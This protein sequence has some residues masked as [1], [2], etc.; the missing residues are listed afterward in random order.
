MARR[1][2]KPAKPK[3]VKVRLI[4]RE[5]R[6]G[7]E[8]PGDPY[9]LLDD[10]VGRWHDDLAEAR[11]ALVW[12]YDLKADKDGRLELGKAKKCSD[13][14]RELGAYDLAIFLNYTAW[15]MF[16]EPQRRALLDYE[17]C[18]CAVTMDEVTGEPKQDERGRPVY[19]TR[20]HDVTEFRDVVRRHGLWTQDLADF[21]R[22]LMARQDRAPLFDAAE[23]EG[24]H[25]PA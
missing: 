22:T 7:E 14:D 10:L 12:K 3:P 16:E 20:K 8:P 1:R 15:V 9:G 13:S 18:H 11:I 19:R 2:K 5:P 17:L 23:K 24:E 21:A 4:P 25:A 6:P